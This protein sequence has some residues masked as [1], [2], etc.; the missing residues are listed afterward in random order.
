MGAVKA[1]EMAM[2]LLVNS[3]GP[4]GVLSCARLRLRQTASVLGKDYTDR[5]PC[6]ATPDAT[7]LAEC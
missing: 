7:S 1:V 4:D 3:P 5:N 6:Q 2:R